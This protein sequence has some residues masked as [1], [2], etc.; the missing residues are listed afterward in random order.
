M[1]KPGFCTDLGKILVSSASHP[2]FNITI[3]SQHYSNVFSTSSL[4]LATIITVVLHPHH[5]HY[6]HH[7]MMMMEILP[8]MVV[9]MN[10]NKKQADRKLE[11]ELQKEVVHVQHQW[12]AREAR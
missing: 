9:T 6:Y 5:H 4:W 8:T 10:Q 11:E 7:L 12:Q 3:N 1:T 2:P